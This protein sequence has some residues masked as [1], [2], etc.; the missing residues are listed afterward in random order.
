M[1]RKP[2]VKLLK[3]PYTYAFYDVNSNRVTSTNRDIFEKLE[4]VLNAP[5][6]EVDTL[7]QDPQIQNLIEKEYLST[8]RPA[9]IRHP[10]TDMVEPLLENKLSRITLQVTQ[11]CNFRC[12][13]CSY[14]N[15][16]EGKQRLHNSKTMSLETAQKALRFLFRHSANSDSINVGFYGGEPFLNFGLIKEMVSYAKELFLFRPLTFSITTNGSVFNDEIA[17]FCMENPIDLKISLDG[18]RET[19]DRN[20]KLA[21]T[22]EGTFDLV[23]SKMKWLQDHYPA[24]AERC[25]VNMVLDSTADYDCYNRV[26]TD[27]EAVHKNNATVSLVDTAMIAQGYE[28]DERFFVKYQ[29]DKFLGLMSE[30]GY[31]REDALSPIST[32]AKLDLYKTHEDMLANSPMGKTTA[33]GGPC[34]PGLL[35]LLVDIHG[36]LFPCERCSETSR[37]MKIGNLDDG[38]DLDN[39]KKQLNVGQIAQENCMN[40]WAMRDCSVCAASIEDDDVLS[41]QKKLSRCRDIRVGFHETLMNLLTLR[42]GEYLMKGVARQ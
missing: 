38:F 23:M 20:R 18:N 1:N 30:L 31:I 10:Y 34:V 28:M 32:A 33:P 17:A 2:F 27:Y 12:A 5:D 41:E 7:M 14:T 29:Y 11:N 39:I 6:S 13:Y 16:L 36:N 37:V 42:D 26:F 4:T 19:H 25:S 8:N 3:T 9:A 24:L 22:G 35:R 40:C 15:P 21:S